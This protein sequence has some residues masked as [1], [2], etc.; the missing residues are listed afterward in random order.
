MDGPAQERAGAG[1]YSGQG[2]GGGGKSC[3]RPGLLRSKQWVEDG[4][5]G[6]ENALRANP[7]D[8]PEQYEKQLKDLQEAYGEAMPE[9]RARK[10]YGP[11]RD[12]KRLLGGSGGSESHWIPNPRSK[13]RLQSGRMPA[14]SQFSLPRSHG[15]GFIRA[16]RLYRL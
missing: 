14:V 13:H 4:K 10:M 16:N 2:D 1:D 8:V 11:P 9:L 12:C 6:M 7:Q 5:H 3:V 15:Q